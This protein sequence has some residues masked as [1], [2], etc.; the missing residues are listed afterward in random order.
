M[1]TENG[2]NLRTESLEGGGSL[3]GFDSLMSARAQAL[4][5][6]LFCHASYDRFL[7]SCLSPPGHKT[8][9]IALG[10]LSPEGIWK[11]RKGGQRP[12]C[13]LYVTQEIFFP[14]TSYW[15]EEQDMGVSSCK[16]GLRCKSWTKGTMLS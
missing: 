4:F 14:L 11:A 6:F 16:G 7:S 1:L 12:N 10:T 2:L 13:Y 3:E 9:A 5:R 8:A 15:S